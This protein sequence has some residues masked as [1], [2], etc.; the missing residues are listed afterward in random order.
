MMLRGHWIFGIIL[1]RWSFD[2]RD[3][4]YSYYCSYDGVVLN[5]G[6][7]LKFTA[8]ID[9]STLLSKVAATTSPSRLDF[10]AKVNSRR[11]AQSD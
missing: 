4:P 2:S 1:T 8:S 10:S 7:T 6:K 3:E 11:Y 9:P 5:T